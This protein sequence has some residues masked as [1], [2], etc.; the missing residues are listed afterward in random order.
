MSLSANCKI[1]YLYQSELYQGIHKG[2]FETKL[3]DLYK[4]RDTANKDESFQYNALIGIAIS[5]YKDF[6]QGVDYLKKNAEESK[7][8]YERYIYDFAVGLAYLDNNK[9]KSLK[10]I[11]A[12]LA[13]KYPNQPA[14]KYLLGCERIFYRKFEESNILLELALNICMSNCN[15]KCHIEDKKAIYSKVLKNLYCMSEG[16][17]ATKKLVEI[18]SNFENLDFIQTD[19]L[20]HAVL[21]LTL[22]DDFDNAKR[23][24]G[25]IEYKY[26]QFCKESYFF[27]YVQKKYSFIHVLNNM[28]VS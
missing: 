8:E 7:D 3:N 11:A 13:K 25:Y 18:T 19:T 1:L 22:V 20:I 2:N 16:K 23:I 10:N 17:V 6:N 24:L 15:S 4:I 14:E 5:R 21:Y 9:L 12:S 26:P 28:Q 27:I